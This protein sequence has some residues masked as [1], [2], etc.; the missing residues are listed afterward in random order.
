ML[1]AA[2]RTAARTITGALALPALL[3]APL[4]TTVVA[5]ATEPDSEATTDSVAVGT[6]HGVGSSGFVAVGERDGV[7]VLQSIA[8]VADTVRFPSV[9]SA[10]PFVVG[11]RCIATGNTVGLRTVLLS[12]ATVADGCL[13]LRTA[14]VAD[15]TVRLIAADPGSPA[16]GLVLG[17]APDGLVTLDTVGTDFEVVTEG[18]FTAPVLA[19]TTVPEGEPLTGTALPGTHVIVVRDDQPLCETDAAGRDDTGPGTW[20]CTPSTPLPV[21]THAL[22]LL[23]V[24]AAGQLSTPSEVTVTVTSADATVDPGD[25]TDPGADPDPGTDPGSDPGEGAGAGA[26]DGVAAPGPSETPGDTVVSVGNGHGAPTGS[27]ATSGPE[28]LAY[29]G[30]SLGAAGAAAAALLAAGVG[31][32]A[33]RRRAARRDAATS[34]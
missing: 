18:E 20:T 30:A 24:S 19:A 28:A 5:S 23:G 34:D 3:A 1:P 32:V 13:Q 7:D 9:G 4:L 17:V 22:Q 27:S 16:D 29:T 33:A 11:D 15:H 2:R 12:D 26:G 14:V 31:L 25:G 10:G 21:G 8:P 6:L